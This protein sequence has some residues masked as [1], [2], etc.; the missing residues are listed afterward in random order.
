MNSIMKK[1]LTVAVVMVLGYIAL[2]SV[3]VMQINGTLSS[4]EFS[5]A[6]EQKVISNMGVK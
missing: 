3:T 2:V 5:T 1:I 4:S 6:V